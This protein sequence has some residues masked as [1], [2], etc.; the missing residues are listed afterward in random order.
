MQPVRKKQHKSAAKRG[1]LVAVLAVLVVLA[2]VLMWLNLKDKNS[3]LPPP[4]PSENQEVTLIGKAP[5]DL[6]AFEL[7][8]TGHASYRLVRGE[9][10]FQLPDKPDFA[11]DQEMLAVMAQD[12]TTISAE[13][14][15]ELSQVPGGEAALGMDGKHFR[16]RAEYTDGTSLTLSFG[17]AA[18]T[19]IP[20]DY[21]MLSGDQAVYTLSPQIKSNLNLPLGALHPIPRIDFS[22]DLLDAL[23]VEDEKSAFSLERNNHFWQVAQ[24]VRYPADPGQIAVMMSAINGMRFAVYVGEADELPLSDY[25]LDAPKRQ[26]TF[27]LAKSVI[28]TQGENAAAHEV[29]AQRF[30][31]AIG[32]D[33]DRIGFYCLHQGSVYQASYASMGFLTTLSLDRMLARKPVIIPINQL[34]SLRVE[35]AQ[36]KRSYQVE[37][38]ERIEKNNALALDEEGRQLYDPVITRDGQES[39]QEA[40]IQEYLKLMDL[41][42]QGKL[43]EGFEP[44]G[45]PLVR[46]VLDAE[47]ILIDLAFYP[48]DAL[49]LAMVVNGHAVYYVTRQA[50]A[51]ISL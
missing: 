18:Y 49:H 8:P 40:F 12:L 6:S 37:L 22:A 17:N 24:P 19:E 5:Q 7:F 35:D 36:A 29:A 13:L 3:A 44:E 23:E 10:G 1:M 33:I 45:A 51:E 28:I 31:F 50:L 15:G 11:L 21:F 30:Q 39:N 2:G 9:S 34:H 4:E 25:G 48:F 32:D 46:Y 43:P 38:V 14:A 26:L 20:S 16:V 41:G 27:H 42:G 47:E